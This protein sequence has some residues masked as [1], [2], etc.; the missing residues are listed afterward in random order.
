[1]NK[2]IL[3]AV[4]VVVC[5]IAAVV[6]AMRPSKTADDMKGGAAKQSAASERKQN[7]ADTKPAAEKPAAAKEVSAMAAYK[8]PAGEDKVGFTLTVDANGAITDAKTQVMSDNEI[9]KKLQQAFGD[10]LPAVL[11]GKK[12]GELSKIDKVGGSSLTTA[13]F[14]QSLEQL[15]AQL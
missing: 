9:S 10:G 13:A 11:K 14:N 5:V 4:T 1:M 2:K 7:A 12:L 8:S 6:Y 15:K 3:I